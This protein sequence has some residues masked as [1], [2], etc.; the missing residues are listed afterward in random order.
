MTQNNNEKDISGRLEFNLF[1]SK[2]TLEFKDKFSFNMAMQ[3]M[4]M[5]RM[6]FNVAEN[7]KHNIIGTETR[8]TVIEKTSEN[9]DENQWIDT[10]T[11]NKPNETFDYDN[12]VKKRDENN[13]IR[14]KN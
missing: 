2:M 3:S 13:L 4:N 10:L 1:G 9:V 6:Y 14:R 8:T 5:L 12:Y 11:N 7:P